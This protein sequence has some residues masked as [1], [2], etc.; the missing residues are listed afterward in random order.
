MAAQTRAPQELGD[1]VDRLMAEGR[2]PP[3]EFGV[4]APNS[5]SSMAP[6]NPR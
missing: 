5:L 6:Q 2:W 3:Q 1:E 4:L